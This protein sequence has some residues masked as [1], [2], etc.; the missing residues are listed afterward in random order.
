M[1]LRMTHAESELTASTKV[2]S[3]ELSLEMV[4]LLSLCSRAGQ[5]ENSKP[6]S[7]SELGFGV[8]DAHCP[9]GIL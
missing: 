4:C 6:C 1:A 9:H 3:Y 8:R 7:S 5:V 2:P